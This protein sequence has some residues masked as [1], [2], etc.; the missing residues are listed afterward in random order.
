M[1]ATAVS[2]ARW[3]SVA[4]AATETGSAKRGVSVAIGQSIELGSNAG[5]SRFG[6]GV[7]RIDPDDGQGAGG[8]QGRDG[9]R[10]GGAER[11]D[12]RDDLP[13]GTRLHGVRLRPL[14]DA[15][16][17]ERIGGVEQNDD[18][19]GGGP[20]RDGAVPPGGERRAVDSVVTVDGEP[21]EREH[22]SLVEQHGTR[23]A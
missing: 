5:G 10:Q 23:D 15:A 19:Q 16:R 18:V 21:A 20:A 11:P 17:E 1:E 7:A 22:R 4:G 8:L 13:V 9:A 12:E 14:A 2:V 3:V 6:W